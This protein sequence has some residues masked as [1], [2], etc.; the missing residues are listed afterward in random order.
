MKTPAC[1]EQDI[2]P[3]VRL[4]VGDVGAIADDA[5][6]LIWNEMKRD[7]TRT[8]GELLILAQRGVCWVC[9]SGYDGCFEVLASVVER[10][11]AVPSDV[12]QDFGKRDRG[13]F[14][15]GGKLGR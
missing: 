8:G 4:A 6:A 15:R 11:Y 5:Y 14:G 2:T 3:D 10:G 12:D 1:L 9:D 13:L 7:G